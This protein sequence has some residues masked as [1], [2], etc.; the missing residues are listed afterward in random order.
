MSFAVYFHPAS[1]TRWNLYQLEVWNWLHVMVSMLWACSGHACSIWPVD[2]LFCGICPNVI[3]SIV[4]CLIQLKRMFLFHF[5]WCKLSQNIVVHFQHFFPWTKH[6][7]YVSIVFFLFFHW[8]TH[9]STHLFIHPSIHL[10]IHPSIHPSIHPY[11]LLSLYQSDHQAI[12]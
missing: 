9:P 4:V 7:F 1:A 8:L 3:N 2:K 10:F 6:E 5:S 12:C 11:F